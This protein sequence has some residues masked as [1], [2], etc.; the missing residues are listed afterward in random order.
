MNLNYNDI[1]TTDGY[2]KFCQENDLPYLKIDYFYTDLRNWRENPIILKEEDKIIITGHS[3]F[4]LSDH[5]SSQFNLIFGT[6]NIS[7]NIN[8]YGLP[9][10]ICNDCDDSPIH[11]IYGNKEVVLKIINEKIDKTNLLYMNFDTST[12]CQRQSTYNLFVDKKWVLIGTKQNTMEGREKFLKEI[13]SSKFVLCPRGNGIDTH[14]IWESL[15]MGSI[16]ILIYENVH[17]EFLDLP[18]LFIKN[19]EEINENYLNEK[20]EYMIQNQYN[21]EKLKISYWFN[22]IKNKIKDSTNASGSK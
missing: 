17:K 15:Y 2:L 19:W 5:I 12:H 13:K 1:I 4:P 22:F 14:R 6:N 16:P 21:M 10:G 3:D 20:Y 18:I 11:K 8:S 9:L 7:S